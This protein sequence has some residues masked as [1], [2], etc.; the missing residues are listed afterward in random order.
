MN[1][2]QWLAGADQSV[3]NQVSHAERNKISGFGTLVLIPAI[4]GLFSMTYALS[5]ITDNTPLFVTGGIVW[6]FVILFIDKFIVST[7]YKTRLENKT[8]FLA[9]TMVRYL[10]ALIVGIAVA[11]PMVLLWFNEGITEAIVQEK[12]NELSAIDSTFEAKRLTVSI[13]LDSLVS[14]KNCKASLLTY[15]QSGFKKE[16]PCG[17]SSGIPGNSRRTAEIGTQ[18]NELGAQI[19][20][21]K[22]LVDS[23]VSDLK[24]QR[25]EDKLSTS[26]NKSFDYLSRVKML[27][28]LQADE[29]NGGHIWWVAFFIMLFFIFV[30][31]LPITMKV[32][33]PYGE[34]EAIRDSVIH[35]TLTFRQ[36]ENEVV[37]EHANG[38]Y[39]DSLRAQLQHESKAKELK[40][41]YE[42]T[43]QTALNIENERKK[44][45]KVAAN[46]SVNIENT[47]DEDLKKDYKNYFS[48]VRNVFN[49]VYTK[50][51]ERLLNYFKAK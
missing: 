36:T 51:H 47:K 7:L 15:E 18:I 39:S 2:F 44:F 35:K 26:N 20:L 6:F 12:R 5:T 38:A 33:T 45:D 14:L 22:I 4:V 37:T 23:L 24:K 25:N 30:D 3:L 43:N 50:T 29:V 8:N 34:Y 27:S 21:E 49:E 31:I 40:D 42:L 41:L 1:I 11:H 32:A 16:L 13:K 48:S 10:F 9:A 17:A 19:V 28:Q 46:I